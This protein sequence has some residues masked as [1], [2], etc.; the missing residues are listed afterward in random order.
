MRQHK[1]EELAHT[2]FICKTQRYSSYAQLLTMLNTIDLFPAKLPVGIT[3][4]YP[5]LQEIKPGTAK[6]PVAFC[7]TELHTCFFGLLLCSIFSCP[8]ST[9]FHGTKHWTDKSVSWMKAVVKTLFHN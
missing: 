9:V 5:L 1:Y 6:S 4:P 2:V 7:D 3:A 8:Y